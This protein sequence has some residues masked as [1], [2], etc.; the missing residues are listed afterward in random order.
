MPSIPVERM[1]KVGNAS[2]EGVTQ[3]VCSKDRLAQV[4]ELVRGVEHVELEEQS[5]FFDIYVD[6]C[7]LEPMMM[8]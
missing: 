2:L 7:F 4:E 1:I 8:M 5:D 3:I 6:G